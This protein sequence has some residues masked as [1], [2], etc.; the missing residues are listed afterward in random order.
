MLLLLS[1]LSMSMD[2]GTKLNKRNNNSWSV[3]FGKFKR[4][5]QEERNRFQVHLEASKKCNFLDVGGRVGESKRLA[6][7]CKYW[8]LDI[9]RRT[10]VS[11]AVLGCDIEDL[12]SCPV[13]SLPGFNIFHSRNTFEHLRE[14]WKVLQ[15]LGALAHKDGALLLVAMPFAWRYHAPSGAKGSEYNSSY[16]DYVRLSHTEMAY[17]AKKYGGFELVTS[18]YEDMY[19]KNAARSYGPTPTQMNQNGRGAWFPN[20]AGV[21]MFYVGRRLPS[22][23]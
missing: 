6:G 4:V 12:R 7:N 15:T 9:G 18:G 20:K 2:D 21:E 14:P 11:R 22:K 16:G 17:L 1:V 5:F 8:V 10:N 13:D 19:T 3:P 23:D